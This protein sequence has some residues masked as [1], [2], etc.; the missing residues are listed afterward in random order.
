VIEPRTP[1]LAAQSHTTLA[2]NR[3]RH[4]KADNRRTIAPC[5]FS[6][7]TCGAEKIPL[8]RCARRDAENST[9]RWASRSLL[10]K[11]QQE[12]PQALPNTDQAKA[13]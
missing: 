11:D 5:P 10:A 2:E 13:A 12:Q 1:E 4:P 8:R 3:A 9:L 7:A 6:E